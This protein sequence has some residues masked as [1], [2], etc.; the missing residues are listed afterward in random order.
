MRCAAGVREGER[1]GGKRA[2]LWQ[3]KINHSRGAGRENKVK[4]N[5]T[6]PPCLRAVDRA[7]F[8]PTEAVR[9]ATDERKGRMG[10]PLPPPSK[11]NCACH[12][13]RQEN[14]MDVDANKE[15]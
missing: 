8:G 7:E 6:C 2:E 13:E 15:S 11:S 14:L 12:Y 9:Q 5:A 1:G 3:S 10:L 4:A